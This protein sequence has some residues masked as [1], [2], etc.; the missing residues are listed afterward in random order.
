[1]CYFMKNLFGYALI[2][3]WFGASLVDETGAPLVCE[4]LLAF[5][6]S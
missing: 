4:N 2:T 6:D 3:N 1:M 5:Y